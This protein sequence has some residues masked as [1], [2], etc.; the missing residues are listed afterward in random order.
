MRGTLVSCLT[1]FAI[2]MP[3]RTGSSKQLESTRIRLISVQAAVAGWLPSAQL[4]C[5]TRAKLTQACGK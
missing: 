1:E 5:R 3:I 2:V 4:A